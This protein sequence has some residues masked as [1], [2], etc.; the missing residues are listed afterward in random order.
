[1]AVAGVEFHIRLIPHLKDLF[2]TGI[3]VRYLYHHIPDLY[4]IMLVGSHKAAHNYLT[5]KLPFAFKHSRLRAQHKRAVLVQR[6]ISCVLHIHFMIVNAH[7]AFIT[8]FGDKLSL[9]EIGLADEIR[10]ES[11]P[12]PVINFLRRP[13]LRHH[14]FVHNNDLIGKGP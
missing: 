4:L 6:K 10:H 11:I 3:E 13:D 7:D 8:F 1:M 9:K 2:I 12:G 5:G 14:T